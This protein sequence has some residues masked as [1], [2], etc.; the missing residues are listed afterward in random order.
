MFAG[1][2]HAYTCVCVCVYTNDTI[3][4]DVY[5]PE[6][7]RG[8]YCVVSF[9]TVCR[10]DSHKGRVVNAWIPATIVTRIDLYTIRK[11]HVATLWPPF[12]RLFR[13]RFSEIRSN[14]NST[15]FRPSCRRPRSGENKPSSS[16][17]TLWTS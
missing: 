4:D 7:P 13:R 9:V 6:H 14:P 16:G 2:L 1:S 8:Q 11:R 10:I 15:R 5:D 3:P 12:V 17:E